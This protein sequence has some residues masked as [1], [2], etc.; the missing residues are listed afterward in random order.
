MQIR[1][2]IKKNVKHTKCTK[3]WTQSL[4][5]AI[6]LIYNIFFNCPNFEHWAKK[7]GLY[8]QLR[9]ETWLK[10]YKNMWKTTICQI[11]NFDIKGSFITKK[12]P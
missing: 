9:I 12:F 4:D 11:Q 2:E 7:F 3:N 8:N 6:A 5:A 10:Y 1:K